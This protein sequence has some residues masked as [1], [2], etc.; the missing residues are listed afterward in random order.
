MPTADSKIS[1]TGKLTI[2]SYQ[3]L[4]SMTPH[5]VSSQVGYRCSNTLVIGLIVEKLFT[6]FTT[7]EGFK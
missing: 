4:S 1:S 6:E 2:S 5:V 7:I 3:N